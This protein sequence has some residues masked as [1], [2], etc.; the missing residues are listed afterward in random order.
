MFN[1]IGPVVSKI[2][3]FEL[4]EEVDGTEDY[5]LTSEEWV[6]RVRRALLSFRVMKI[7]FRSLPVLVRFPGQ[8]LTLLLSLLL[9]ESWN[10]Q[11]HPTN[12][13]TR[14]LRQTW[15]YPGLN[16]KI[17]KASGR[18]VT[19]HLQETTV[20]ISTGHITIGTGTNK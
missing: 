20:T 14:L 1:A 16:L 10:W 5:R 18:S 11:F 12:A 9:S 4:F 17:E 2:D 3:H 8:F 19:L 6:G 13:P 7:A 15:A